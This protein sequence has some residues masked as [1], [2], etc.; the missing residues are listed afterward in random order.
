M[1]QNHPALLIMLIYF[2][3]LYSCDDD[4]STSS[5]DMFIAGET[6]A[7]ET[8]AGETTAGENTA[9]ETTAGENTAGESTAGANTAGESTAGETPEPIIPDLLP[10]DVE[11]LDGAA[12]LPQTAPN[13]LRVGHVDQIEEAFDGQD[14]ACRIGSI[15]L[16]NSIITA[17]I[18]GESSLTQFKRSGGN[19]VDLMRWSALGVDGL[20]EVIVAPGF[21]EVIPKDVKIV[22]DGSDGELAIVQV[23]GVTAGSRILTSYLPSYV[24]RLM[25]VVN[26][27]HLYTQKAEIEIHTW[28]EVG[29]RAISLQMSDF[30]I[31]ADPAQL[32]YPNQEGDR[33]PVSSPYLGAHLPQLSY[34]WRVDGVDSIRVMSLPGLPFQPIISGQLQAPAGSI[35]YTKRILM[36]GDGSVTPLAEKYGLLPADSRR[37]NLGAQVVDDEGRVLSSNNEQSALSPQNLLPQVNVEIHTVA[38]D[39]NFG[40]LVAQRRL[41]ILTDSMSSPLMLSPG[42]YWMSTPQW[43]GGASKERI[44][45]TPGTE[46]LEVSMN[47]LAPASL[48]LGE[49]YTTLQGIPR[50]PVLRGSKW[51]FQP[52]GDSATERTR[53]IHFVLTADEL[54]LPAGT[55]D[56]Q[57]SR[58]WHFS[59]NQQQLNLIAGQHTEVMV[60]LVEELPMPGLSAG[61]FHQHSAPSL[62][63]EVGFKQRILSNI[64]E[65]VGFMVPSDHDVQVD[66]P[67]LVRRFGFDRDVGSPITGLEISPRV[68]HLGAY[69]VSYS[70]DDPS[71]AGGAPPLSLKEVDGDGIEPDTWRLRTMPELITE[72]RS[73]GAAIIQVNHPRDSTGY[74]DTVGFNPETGN[75]P[76][77]HEQWT[78]DFDTI[79][80][81]NGASD[82]C[83]VMRDWQALLLRGEKITAVG[84]SDSHDLGRPV[85]YPRNYLPTQA[86]QSIDISKTEV[87]NALRKGQVSIG[88]GA[89]LELDGELMWGDV[90]SGQAIN[91][92]LIAHTPSFAQLT[93][94]TAYFN[95]HEL[96][97]TSLDTDLTAL[98][99]YQD[100]V[101]LTI[102]HDGFLIFFAEGPRLNFVYPGQPTFA[103][104]NPIWIDADEDGEIALPNPYIAPSTFSTEFCP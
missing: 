75:V 81:F 11:A 38:E 16:E 19:L 49:Q 37:I 31:W 1:S 28:I 63:S 2:F 86:S 50:V 96:W 61:E 85:G 41:N 67:S 93:R 73:R 6:T 53:L 52:Q 66:Y 54:L 100:T 45:I 5:S 84:N 89:Y 40:I 33:I 69:G 21:G 13:S 59:A 18:Q 56:L 62:D 58:G 51:V 26:E 82:F 35:L 4:T 23:R 95:G 29:D 64:A 87:I 79:E 14:I 97:S 76:S 74:F 104:S 78:S 7:G 94:L 72:A 101:S 90:L 12:T 39:N 8:T 55:W 98:Q 48:S 9:G 71:G 77:E 44:T 20:S 57:V 70:P 46:T 36:V 25:N 22:A 92:P 43:V 102:D 42:E 3:G 32:Y 88:G 17:C 10:L 83:A 103:L 27:Y 68:G 65:G 30:V 15:R 34:L 24:P 47:L 99:D 60:N 80:V 91:I